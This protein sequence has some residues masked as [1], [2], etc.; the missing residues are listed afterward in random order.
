MVHIVFTLSY[1]DCINYESRKI[2]FTYFIYVYWLPQK[3][4]SVQSYIYTY[5]EICLNDHLYIEYT[6]SAVYKG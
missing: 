3:L 6:T 4:P 1:S 5:R 2:C